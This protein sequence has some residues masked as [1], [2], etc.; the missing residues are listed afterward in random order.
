VRFARLHPDPGPVHAGELL[1]GLAL[2]DRAPP[3]RPYVALNFVTSVDGRAAVGGSAEPLGDDGDREVFFGLRAAVDAVLT[4]TGTLRV[5]RYGRLVGRPERRAARVR[6][7]LAEDPLAVVV[8]R[9]GDVPAEPA[10][11]DDPHST[12]AVF[13]PAGTEAPARG[14]DVRLEALEPV[15]LPAVLERLRT[16]YG[17][18][19][20]LC[21]GGPTLASAMLGERLVDEL[22]LTVAPKLAGGGHEPGMAEGLPLPEPAGLELVWVLERAGS[23][24]LRYRLSG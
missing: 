15:T 2:A 4:G 8:T 5:E 10:I 6:A 14:A 13:G 23:L 7:G 17:V 16:G 3:G 9:S 11:W 12:V 20:L 18:R 22:F 21:E 1:G 24:F 19:S